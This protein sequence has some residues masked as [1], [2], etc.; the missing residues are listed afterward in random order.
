MTAHAIAGEEQMDGAPRRLP[1]QA[2][3]LGL[4]RAV[5]EAVSG[6]LEIAQVLER[7]LGALNRVTGHE[8]SSLHLISADG[9]RLVLEG[10]RGL[11]PR[12]REINRV[13]AVGAG[14]IGGVA[15]SGLPRRVPDVSR[16][17]DLLPAAR[18]VVAADGI[19]GFVCVPI[20]A[21]Q[22]ILG[23]LSLGRRTP[24][25]FTRAEL[26]LLECVA[27]QVGLAL[28]NARLHA[29]ARRRVEALERSRAASVRAERISAVDS[30]AAG[31]AHEINN[32]LTI[33]LGQIHVL[34]HGEI[35]AELSRGLAVIDTAAKRAAKIVRDL[36]AFAEPTPARRAPCPVPE[37]IRTVLEQ[38]EARLASSRV[39]VR[40]ELDETPIIW[41]DASQL[42]Q[43]LAHLV[44]NARHAMASAHGGGTLWLRLRRLPAGVRI[45][46][47]DDGPGIAPEHLP[48]VFNPFFTTKG[49][50][51]G[52]GLGLAVSHGIVKEHGGR[53]WAENRSE[54]GALFVLE[55]PAS[56]RRA[57]RHPVQ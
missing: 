27:D 35:P 18:E 47:A 21:R 6:S 14:L 26:H 15:A 32:P 3:Y 39:A 53:L 23:T 56:L 46:V 55:L 38:D 48:R 20:R 36:R 24:S 40:L 34:R 41:G 44:D 5:G 4:L 7:A 57:E 12:L 42:S 13:M 52:R 33:I 16:V 28:D 22:R 31:V 51:E 1:T 43:A 9:A 30:L 25:P 10:D 29:E 2:R 17:K 19:R 49:P 8:I 45:E 50:D 54:G 11:S 37:L